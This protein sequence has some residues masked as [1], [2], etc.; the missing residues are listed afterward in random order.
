MT[1]AEA[2][3]A[4]MEM[5]ASIIREEIGVSLI[6]LGEEC[7]TRIRTRSKEESW[8]DQTGNLRSSIGYA[9]F[10]Y[11][12]KLMSSAFVSIPGP[13]GSG[14]EGTQKGEQ[15]INELASQFANTYSLV[16][17]AGMDYAEYVEAIKGKD[18]LASTELWA[19]AR[20]DRYV[21]DARARAEYR[22]NKFI[23]SL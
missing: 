15:Y 6:R 21:T 22:I 1:P 17:V 13:Q 3:N 23:D 19:K 5:A 20:V 12:Q 4:A 14:A 11:G 10:E 7:V 16:V 18:V 9:V 8:I 2:L